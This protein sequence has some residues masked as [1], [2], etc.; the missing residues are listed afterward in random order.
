MDKNNNDILNEYLADKEVTKHKNHKKIKILLASIIPIIFA[1]TILLVI[2]FK[3]NLDRKEIYDIDI[4]ISRD[5]YQIYYFTEI[6]TIKTKFGFVSNISENKEI[7]I[8]SNFL[9]FQT[10]R[11][12]LENN[13]FLNNA[14][15]IILNTKYNIDTEERQV[16]SF[17]IFDEETIKQFKNNPDA[18]KYPMA[19]FS[20]YENGTIYDINLPDK[21]DK[22]ITYSIIELIENIIPKLSRNRT[23]DKDNGL[24]LKIIKKEKKK[25]LIENYSTR[26]IKEFKKSKFSK[27]IERDINDEQLTNIRTHSKLILETKSENGESTFGL[28]DFFLQQESKI[29]LTGIKIE[30]K[31]IDI[32]QNLYKYYNFINSKDL[33]KSFGKKE[34]G[35]NQYIK[36][37]IDDTN[38]KKQRKLIQNIDN[39]FTVKEFNVLGI[40]G[41]IKVKFQ[42]RGTSLQYS[43]IEIIITTNLGEAKF[44]ESV[45]LSK[46]KTFRTPD[47]P[48]L[49][50]VFPNFPMAGVGL[51]AFASL[52]ISAKFM[53]HR[54]VSAELSISGS[55]SAKADVW[56]NSFGI[57]VSG[58]AY[59]TI[60]SASL[61][62]YVNRII[63]RDRISLIGS[64]SAGEVKIFVEA[65]MMGIRQFH[66][67]KVFDGWSKNF[68]FK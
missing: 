52:T 27:Y 62:G 20:F 50:F 44:G 59:G 63:S 18:T 65:N 7:I 4:T 19:I 48:I 3:F 67:W 68:Y 21:I 42:I 17:N 14:T 54:I 64:L 53:L 46:S 33:I 41:S 9:V 10:G 40:K 57:S 43:H 60:V 12:K 55:I 37:E 24:S 35:T 22:N 13:D 23:E 61:T 16:I 39:T 6:K 8:N 5:I 45:M 26:E 31:I 28:K 30:K 66:D 47:I 56:A 15:L 29:N 51:K 1:S 2:Y 34:N 38:N 32:I 36:D 25:T 49:I 58:G 11:E